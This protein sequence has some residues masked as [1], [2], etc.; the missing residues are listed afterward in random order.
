MSRET[1]LVEHGEIAARRGQFAPTMLD[2]REIVAA[3]EERSHP[4]RKGSPVTTTVVLRNGE[5]YAYDGERAD[6]LRAL[7]AMPRKWMIGGV[8][9]Q[10]WDAGSGLATLSLPG[11]SLALTGSDLE[12]MKQFI[13]DQAPSILKSK[14]NDLAGLMQKRWENH[15]LKT[16]LLDLTEQAPAEAAE[17]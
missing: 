17:E 4:T 11:T 16:R 10:V 9:F 5:A 12:E 15:L 8:D 7:G 6:V 13:L 2:P 3:H 1:H 14:S